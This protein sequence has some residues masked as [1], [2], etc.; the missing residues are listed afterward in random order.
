MQSLSV[1]VLRSRLGVGTGFGVV[2]VALE[3]PGDHLG[4]SDMELQQ[5]RIN[6]CR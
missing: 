3:D 6:I 5:R 2:L 1:G 4:D